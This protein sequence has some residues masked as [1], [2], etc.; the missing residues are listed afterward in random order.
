[1]RGEKTKNIGVF[2]MFL[3][4]GGIIG[5]ILGELIADSSWLSGI[6]PYVVKK[7]LIFDMAP[8]VPERTLLA[9]YPFP[10]REEVQPLSK[11]FC[12][13]IPVEWPGSFQA[14]IEPIFYHLFGLVST[15]L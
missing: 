14:S 1:M 15:M 9:Q 11:N 2:L 10:L 12:R 6:A 7:F 3:I 4:L 8:D 5:G 13:P